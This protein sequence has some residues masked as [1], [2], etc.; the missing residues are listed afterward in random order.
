MT[1]KIKVPTKP[2]ISEAK[3]FIVKYPKHPQSIAWNAAI[4]R[5]EAQAQA[6]AGVTPVAPAKRK[7]VTLTADIV[8]MQTTPAED[9]QTEVIKREMLSVFSAFSLERDKVAEV[10]NQLRKTED[11]ERTVRESVMVRLAKLSIKNNWTAAHI[12]DGVNLALKAFAD[13]HNGQMLPSSL[14]QFKGE[15]KRAMHPS[16]REHISEAIT[17]GNAFWGKEVDNAKA[18]REANKHLPEGTKAVAP[19]EPLKRAFQRR[20]HLIAGDKGLLQA[21]IDGLASAGLT[22]D[23][24]A[25]AGY[26]VRTTRE[27]PDEAAK[28]IARLVKQISVIHE[29]FPAAELEAIIAFVKKSDVAKALTRAKAKKNLE[30]AGN[31]IKAENAKA[32]KRAEK[33]VPVIAEDG[34]EEEIAEDTEEDLELD[35]TDA[36]FADEE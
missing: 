14:N 35:A 24:V 11:A 31:T 17:T 8:G 10:Q 28:V 2:T 13:N 21:H 12:E 5:K 19:K 16:A 9:T 15:L 33:V 29:E 4:M 18:V 26:R 20:Y 7:P 36:L 32:L 3:A 22:D 23:P 25:L 6:L 34:E 30:L 27:D 1:T